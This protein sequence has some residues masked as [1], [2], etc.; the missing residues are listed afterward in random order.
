[1]VRRTPDDDRSFFSTAGI[2]DQGGR[3]TPATHSNSGAEHLCSLR[4]DR[5]TEKNMGNIG[6]VTRLRK[7]RWTPATSC[8]DPETPW[9]SESTP[10]LRSD[11]V[12]KGN[13]P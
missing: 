3:H 7:G 11:W 12:W 2:R 10:T 1:M 13:L 6:D 4:S 5:G 9:V 8:A